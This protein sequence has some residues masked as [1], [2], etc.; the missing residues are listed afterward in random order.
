MKKILIFFLLFLAVGTQA[1]TIITGKVVDEKT[2]V[3]LAGITIYI[4]SSTIGTTTDNDGKF[5]LSVPYNGKVELVASHLNYEKKIVLITPNKNEI[6]LIALKPQSNTLK[7][8]VVKGKKIKSENFNKWGDLFTKILMGTDLHFAVNAKIKNPETLSFYFD[9]ESNELIAYAKEPLVIE[10]SMLAYRIKLDLENFKYAFN[11]DVLQFEYSTFFEELLITKGKEA[12]VRAWRAS[13]YYGSQMHF[14]RSVYQNNLT[15]DGFRLYAYRTH[16]NKEKERVRKI[17][18]LKIAEIYAEKNN[19]NYDIKYLFKDRDTIGYYQMIMK[20]ND[21]VAL[22]TSRVSLR[23]LAVLNRQLD[24]V[25]FNFKDTIMVTYKP[26][27]L[28]RQNM[29]VKPVETVVAKDSHGKTKDQS[30]YMYFVEDGGISVQS[31]GYFPEL[32]LFVYGNMS[33]RRIAQVLPWDY[34][35]D[36]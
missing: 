17:I 22:D 3:S 7:E 32:R 19:P 5:I 14:M 10:N 36:K 28:A 21:I 23:K 25:K 6:L 35:P 12:M 33:E 29:S 15:N 9:K 4:N 18:Q 27:E 16:K 13:A 1:Q 2:N 30:S 20:Q 8:V 31:N 11:T 26:N 34:D 24:V